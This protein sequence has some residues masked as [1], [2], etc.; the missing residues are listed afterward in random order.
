MEET[1]FK[2]LIVT[3]SEDKKFTRTI[4]QRSVSE[5]PEGDILIRVS[6]SSLNYK[7]ALSASGN[8]GVTRR[9]PHTPGIDAS[10]VVAQSSDTLFKEGDLVLVTGFD[11]GMNTSGGFSEYIRV[12]S[13]WVVPLPETMSLREAMIYGT[14]GFTAALS[15]YRLIANG[16]LPEQGPVLVTGATGGVGSIAVALLAKSGYEVVAVTTKAKEIAYLQEIGAKEVLSA[17]EADDQSGRP[18]LKP[19]WAGVVDTVGGNILSTAIKTTR[20]GGTVT[21][22]GNVTSGE[23]HTSI[24]PFILKGVSLLGIDSVN[25]PNPLRTGV[26]KKLANEWKLDHLDTITTELPSLEALEERINLI[27]EGKNRGRVIVRICA[28]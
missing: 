5:L 12:P 22:C 13:S 9:Y 25:C 18:L 23:L 28:D 21:C 11:L 17:V 26:W 4:G 24:Y 14:A 2:A 8:K 7:D 20:Y 6:Y 1:C 10:G 19:R 3:E 16:V 27:L 15:C